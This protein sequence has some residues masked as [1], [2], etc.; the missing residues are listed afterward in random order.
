MLILLKNRF[1][2]LDYAR[3]QEYTIEWRKT[4]IAPKQGT[5]INP[6]L[7]KLETLYNECK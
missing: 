2:A 7:Y 5:E 4:C 1:V 6:W 3:K